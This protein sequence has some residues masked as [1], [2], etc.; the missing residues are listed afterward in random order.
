MVLHYDGSA[1]TWINGGSND[2]LTSVWVDNNGDVWAAGAFYNSLYRLHAGTWSVADVPFSDHA[3]YDLWGAGES[4]FAVG[5]R[6]LAAVR[7]NGVWQQFDTHTSERI[8]AIWGMSEDRVYAAA[9][10]ENEILAFDGREWKPMHVDNVPERYVSSLWGT[11]PTNM[12][13]VD[14]RGAM[15]HYDGQTWQPMERVLSE[16]IW[17]VSGVGNEVIAI[18]HSGVVSYR[19]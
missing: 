13:V 12:F 11:A 8:S 15:L 5:S 17:A 10:L 7:R 19:R 18:N 4:M 9:G 2:A 3:I 14:D 1:W 16:G 6:G